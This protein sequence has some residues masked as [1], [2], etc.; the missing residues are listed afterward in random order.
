MDSTATIVTS[1]KEIAN[2]VRA[3][4]SN[5]VLEVDPSFIDLAETGL[6]AELEP[7]FRTI[8]RG[9][10][11]T[12]RTQRGRVI[13]AIPPGL[14][15]GQLL[16]HLA[17]TVED[18]VLVYAPLHELNAAAIKR[19]VETPEE[20][21]PWFLTSV[22][23][24]RLTERLLAEHWIRELGE[25]KLS[26]P[27]SLSLFYLQLIR[28]VGSPSWK[29][30]LR[31]GS[32]VAVEIDSFG[33]TIHHRAYPS[34]LNGAFDVTQKEVQAQWPDPQCA[35]ND[36]LRN[37]DQ[38]VEQCRQELERA[39][40]AGVCSWPFSYGGVSFGERP[41]R[42]CA[43][44]TGLLRHLPTPTPARKVIRVY[45]QNRILFR[46]ISYYRDGQSPLNPL[47]EK[48][49]VQ[50]TIEPQLPSAT[51]AA[52]LDRLDGYQLNL[53]FA[54]FL[55]L[56]K[57]GYLQ[58]ANG[59]L[60]VTATGQELL[61]QADRIRLTSQRVYLILRLLE[62]IQTDEASYADVL[63]LI[64]QNFDGKNQARPEKQ[65]AAAHPT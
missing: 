16:L 41:V 6:N 33:G 27:G 40:Y 55:K 17:H 62:Y 11:N 20:I 39:Y 1:R 47:P 48:A 65:T 2:A 36:L 52:F 53:D 23:A 60:T 8:D 13:C 19:A 57:D 61:F 37:T 4:V 31:F 26:Y 56:V 50:V 51:Q 49:Q 10:E 43:Q 63:G 5:R 45:Q 38:D 28:N 46:S 35:I 64:Q 42:V 18:A 15:H 21:D 58:T 25:E 3:C 54:S 29:R 59:N 7:Q 32:C 9:M 14:S 30:Q 12:V 22:A 44:A 34:H 24:H